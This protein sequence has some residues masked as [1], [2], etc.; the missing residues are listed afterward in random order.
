MKNIERGISLLVALLVLCISVSAQNDMSHFITRSGNKLMEG[1]KEYRFISF[2]IPN[3]HLVE[4][5]MAFEAQ[6]EWRF[7][8]EFEITDALTTIKQMGGR[9]A[10]MYVISI[11]RKTGPNA[12]PCH[13]KKPGEFNEDAFRALDKVLEVANRV[14]VRVIIPFVDNWKWWGGA[15]QYAEYRDKTAADFWTDPDVIDDFKKT[16]SFVLNR[17][18]TYTGTLYKDDKAVLAWETGNE[19]YC[20]YSWTKQIAAHIKSLD[21]NHLVWDGLYIGNR[22]IQPGALE[23]PNI[24]IVSSHHYPGENRGADQMVADIRKFREQI[25]GKKVYI[26]GEFGFI[27]PPD[28]RKVL[29][30]VI[31]EGLSGA[32]IWSLRYHNRDGGFYWHSEPASASLYNPYHYPGFPSG[33]SWNET[34]TLKVMREKAFEIRGMK[35]PPLEIP[36]APKLLP[37]SSVAAISWQGS[38]GALSYDVERATEINGPWTVVGKDVDDTWVRYRPLFSDPSVEIGKSYFYRVR[39]KNASGSSGPSN[40][41]GPV[42]VNEFTLVDELIDFG[43]LFAR[44]GNVTLETANAR[45]YKEDPHR[46]KASVGASITYKTEKPLHSATVLALMEAT[47][48][49]PEFYVSSDGKTF[50]KVA[51]RVSSFPTAINLYGYKLPV[52]YEVALSGNYLKVVFTGDIQVSRV[53]I[54][55]GR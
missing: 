1:D 30:T 40:I 13:V 21:S 48:V 38:V 43:K 25:G 9:A 52:K 34:A 10:R 55:Y 17:R 35:E 50:A 22:E 53:E 24:D 51:A 37:I 47:Q 46:L 4:D 33:E 2:N 45:P 5:N 7:P 11:C 23:D 44:E 31:S 3:L 42:Q 19:I 15:E 39:A 6:N 12:I 20:P 32:M 41:V 49:D 14:G 29:D 26:V 18:N 27:P 54:K 16:V 8:D 36:P 28:I